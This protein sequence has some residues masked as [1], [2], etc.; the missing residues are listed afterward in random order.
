MALASQ[1]A[2]NVYKNQLENLE[3]NKML[4][5]MLVTGLAT[6]QN[7]ATEKSKK[8]A[9]LDRV[10]AKIGFDTSGKV[11]SLDK[12]KQ[13]LEKQISALTLLQDMTFRKLSV[14]TG[15][16]ITTIDELN[17]SLAQVASLIVESKLS[18]EKS[19]FL[20]FRSVNKNTHQEFLQQVQNYEKIKSV[21]IQNYLLLQKLDEAERTLR[22]F[23]GRRFDDP[24]ISEKAKESNLVTLPTTMFLTIFGAIMIPIIVANIKHIPGMMKGPGRLSEKLFS[25]AVVSVLTLALAAIP[26]A[27][28]TFSANSLI[29][30]LNISTIKNR[31]RY[32]ISKL[33]E[34]VEASDRDLEE[35]LLNAELILESSLQ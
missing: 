26:I 27:V 17:V 1:S 13:H 2:L 9:E 24:L 11:D 29:D 34:S 16:N 4:E 10:I 31:Y 7:I 6:V 28:I 33:R 18:V 8:Q 3:K 30:D 14:D 20:L 21:S 12:S 35:S 22:A 25:A 23:E 32:E 5:A 19:R 15:L